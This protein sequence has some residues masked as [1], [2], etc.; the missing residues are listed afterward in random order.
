MVYEV[1]IKY[2]L[3]LIEL[4]GSIAF[5]GEDGEL[6]NMSETEERYFEF[7]AVDLFAR[8]KFDDVFSR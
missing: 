7:Y 1:T 6:L 8:Q 5:S 3:M 2:D 4:D